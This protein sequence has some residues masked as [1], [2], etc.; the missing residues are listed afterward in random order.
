M[1]RGCQASLGQAPEDLSRS[2][3]ITAIGAE[4]KDPVKRKALFNVLTAR[5]K[6]ELSRRS[7]ERASGLSDLELEKEIEREKD[8]DRRG[9]LFT[10]LRQREEYR[11]KH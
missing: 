6:G 7:I 1:A 4:K 2:E 10:I 11:R 5:E 3:L 8:L 9:E